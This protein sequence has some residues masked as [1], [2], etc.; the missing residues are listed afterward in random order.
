MVKNVLYTLAAFALI[1][2]SCKKDGCT[3]VTATNYD[4]K[5]DKDDGSCTFS[6]TESTTNTSGNTDSTTTGG[7]TTTTTSGSTDS[8]TTEVTTDTT[9][10]TTIDT[11][12]VALALGDFKVD[13]QKYYSASIYRFNQGNNGFMARIRYSNL[14][15]SAKTIDVNVVSA[16]TFPYSTS[17]TF[18][19]VFYNEYTDANKNEEALV[20]FFTTN[21]N[22]EGYHI[23]VSPET[24]GNFSIYCDDLK[25]LNGEK[26]EFFILIPKSILD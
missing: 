5:A 17:K 10:T 22:T 21:A 3:D 15:E 24:D 2:T 20:E 12:S 13:G 11:A 9:T 18:T 1:F 8:T 23:K 25:G 14:N 6:T 26:F 7:N 16:D 19:G 4:E